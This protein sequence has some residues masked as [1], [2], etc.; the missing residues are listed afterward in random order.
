[1]LARLCLMV[2]SISSGLAKRFDIEGNLADMRAVGLHPSRLFNLASTAVLLT[3][4]VLILLYL[5]GEGS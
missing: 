4:P 3:A 2:I 1:M 5:W